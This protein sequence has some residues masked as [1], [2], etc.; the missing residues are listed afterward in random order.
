MKLYHDGEPAS[1]DTLALAEM[2]ISRTQQSYYSEETQPPFKPLTEV[3]LQNYDVESL[4][5]QWKQAISK[6]LGD[7]ECV[8]D[9]A[10]ADSNGEDSLGDVASKMEDI[11]RNKFN[12]D[13]LDHRRDRADAS[14][15]RELDHEMRT[16]ENL[17]L[18]KYRDVTVL[19][20]R[21]IPYLLRCIGQ[22]SSNLIPGDDVFEFR[23]RA[24][25]LLDKWKPFILRDT[26]ASPYTWRYHG[27]GWARLVCRAPL[28]NTANKEN[29]EKVW[30]DL[31]GPCWTLDAVTMRYYKFRAMEHLEFTS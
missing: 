20:Q 8:K 16:V 31:A 17:D 14:L 13:W 2:V 26:L 9:G 15:H 7:S 23:S 21:N 25:K 24:K 22:M 30:E 18:E 5:I 1:I 6:I 12:R 27:S 28:D 4:E 29:A 11:L 3:D 19:A 10:D